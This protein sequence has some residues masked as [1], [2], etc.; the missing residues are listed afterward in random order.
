MFKSRR[1]R[2][3]KFDYTPRFYDQEKDKRE[4]AIR[5]HVAKETAKKE[6]EEQGGFGGIVTERRNRQKVVMRRTMILIGVTACVAYF[7]YV[8]GES[9]LLKVLK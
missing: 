8:F 7:L 6:I 9:I 1:V 2:N 3:K 4:Q 5:K